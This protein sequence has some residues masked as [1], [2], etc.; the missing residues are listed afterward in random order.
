MK[1]ITTLSVIIAFAMVLPQVAAQS[2]GFNVKNVNASNS[3]IVGTASESVVIH[4]DLVSLPPLTNSEI[5]LIVDP[6]EGSIVYATDSD[7]LLVFDGEKWRRADGQN[8][9]YLIIPWE[10]GDS[11]TDIRDSQSYN[12]VEI[13]TQCWMAENLNIG[14]RIDGVV[15]QTNNSTIEKFCYNNDEVNCNLYGGLYQW[16][17]MMQYVTTEV[18][19]GICPDGWHLPT[20]AEWAVLTDFLGGLSV[21]GAKMKELGTLHWVDPNIGA[22]NASGFTAL[23][24]GHRFSSDGTFSDAGSYGYWWSATKNSIYDDAWFRYLSYFSDNVSRKRYSKS[25]G[26]SV[27]CERDF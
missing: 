13:G 25:Y 10:C 5:L 17:E 21:A 9:S 2:G 7:I 18:A 23:P 22:T 16:D 24:G 20:D 14:T 15:G 26:F 3:L 8:D 1:Y 12:T 27:R 19:Q 4:S 11:Y 6:A